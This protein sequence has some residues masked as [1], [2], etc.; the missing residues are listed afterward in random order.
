M[1]SC[2]THEVSLYIGNIRGYNGEPFTKD[3]VIKA[4]SEYQIAKGNECV[5]VRVTSTTFVV[6]DY[7][8]R[9]FEVAAINYPRFPKKPVAI[10]Q[11]M[12]GLANCLLIT[13][14]QNRISVV[15]AE[16]TIL[17]EAP[18]PEQHPAPK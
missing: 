1:K 6:K 17:I 10:E 16:N 8:E 5:S 2:Q 18:N 11:F 14:Q 15:G 13:F 4:I 7:V 12:V 3:D 9:G